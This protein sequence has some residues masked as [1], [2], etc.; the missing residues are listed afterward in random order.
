MDHVGL[1]VA[2][3]FVVL[4]LVQWK[5]PLRRQ[6]FST[7]TRL[8][9]NAILATPSF[10]ASHLLLIPIPFV[11]AI[12]AERQHFGL[13]NWVALPLPVAVAAGILIYDYGYYWWHQL[14]H[15]GAFFWRFHN[16]HHTD[17][18][19]DV[20]TASRFHFGEVLISIFFRVAVVLLF[21]FGVWTLAVYEVLFVLANQFHHS[22]WRLPIRLERL[23]NAVFVT[24]RMHGTHHS[25][26]QRETNSNW[27]TVFSIWDRLHH[28]LR[29]DVPQ[30]EITIGVA[31]YRNEE[32]LTF[33][34]L[35][36]LPFQKQRA[37]RLPNGAVPERSSRDDSTKLAP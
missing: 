8:A 7:L 30:N 29:I 32:E 15:L 12:W 11:L 2:A 19:M 31:A 33:G 16:V 28:T 1:V 14:M 17:L 9:R 35:F 24:P 4:L 23:L 6:H 25:I 21:G 20:S 34:K 36:V 27:G 18:D 10:V 37:W 13:F 26:V 5:W 22:N 3:A